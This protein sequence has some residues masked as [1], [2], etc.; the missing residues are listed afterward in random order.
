MTSITQLWPR[1]FFCDG[2]VDPLEAKLSRS[3]G[4]I[5]G[6]CCKDLGEVPFN[7]GDPRYGR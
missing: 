3:T 7:L 2:K 5:Y 1:C 6:P 4:K